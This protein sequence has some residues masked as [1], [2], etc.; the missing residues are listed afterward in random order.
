MDVND[1]E[2]KIRL[3]LYSDRIGF[4]GITILGV[5]DINVAL[6]LGF[7][8]RKYK[9]QVSR[10]K[11][12]AKDFILASTNLVGLLLLCVMHD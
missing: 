12:T 10:K 2:S 3:S 11:P 6:G 1:L 9:V 8:A 7:V 5:L 4:G